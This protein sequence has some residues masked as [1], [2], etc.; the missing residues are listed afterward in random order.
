[1]TDKDR[2][3]AGKVNI[4]NKLEIVK[5]VLIVLLSIFGFGYIPVLYYL[6][7]N[8]G[9]KCCESNDDPF[10]KRKDKTECPKKDKNP[11]ADL[12]ENV[13][14][15]TNPVENPEESNNE[16]ETQNMKDENDASSN[17]I[18]QGDN[19]EGKV[20][21][22]SDRTQQKDIDVEACTNLIDTYDNM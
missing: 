13:K 4:I 15:I 14:V 10:A 17:N 2:I 19:S 20:Y 18:Q 11:Q 6:I 16:I 22:K 8:R 12:G 9:L 5:Y 1:M 7:K 3:I 21:T